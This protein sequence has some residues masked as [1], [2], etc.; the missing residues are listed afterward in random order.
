MNDI[1]RLGTVLL[2]S[3]LAGCG[4]LKLPHSGPRT[5]PQDE[6]PGDMAR[7]APQA[8]RAPR[9]DETPYV[10]EI[11]AQLGATVAALDRVDEQMRAVELKLAAAQFRQA[12]IAEEVDA[13][14]LELP[15]LLH[16]L[17]ALDE[18]YQIAQQ[19]YADLQREHRRRLAE[20]HRRAEAL[21]QQRFE[22]QVAAAHEARQARDALRARIGALPSG[23]AEAHLLARR[24]DEAR[25]LVPEA[26]QAY[27]DAEIRRLQSEL[28]A[29]ALSNQQLQQ[30]RAQLSARRQA[31]SDALLKY[32]SELST[33][34]AELAL[35][36]VRLDQLREHRRQLRTRADVLWN[37]LH[38][39][40]GGHSRAYV[41]LAPPSSY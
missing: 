32:R 33:V 7:V 1:A 26:Y 12:T 11:R 6:Q 8:P 9:P 18:E 21:A 27:V 38:R 2:I 15:T 10:A 16:Q 28:T 19:E 35:L 29:L 34:R 22:A 31:A 23:Q 13:L 5:T 3:F 14:C 25:W 4:A 37:A 36:P 41:W 40:S 17:R 20:A 30:R 39:A 24:I